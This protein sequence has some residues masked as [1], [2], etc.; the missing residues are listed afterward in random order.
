MAQGGLEILNELPIEV[1][2]PAPFFYQTFDKP[3]FTQLDVNTYYRHKSGHPFDFQH[4]F[5]QPEEYLSD[6]TPFTHKA[7]ILINAVYWDPKA[8]KLYGHEEMKI[9]AFTIKV[10]ADI[11]CDINGSVPSTI[12]S[13]TI[14]D[15]VYDYNAIS[16]EQPAFSN[17]KN[18]SVMAIDNLPNE[19]P[20]NASED[21]GDQLINNVLPALLK[22]DKSGLIKNATIAEQNALT[23]RFS[24]LSDY[25]KG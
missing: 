2:E 3:V 15:P 17:E 4:F 16:G 9:E 13:S 12:R 20:R 14:E 6:F 10:I 5:K 19:L 7:D 22:G 1:V 21:F 23:E 8:P 18:I 25:V 24:Y 11:T